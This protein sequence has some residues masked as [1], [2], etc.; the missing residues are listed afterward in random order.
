MQLVCISRKDDVSLMIKYI[1]NNTTESAQSKKRKVATDN[2]KINALL[3]YSFIKL[4]S[5]PFLN[6]L[7][8]DCQTFLLDCQKS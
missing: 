3:E 8:N 2:S 5:Y 7:K 1:F 4:P 6:Y